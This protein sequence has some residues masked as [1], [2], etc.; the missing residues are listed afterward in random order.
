M[1]EVYYYHIPED[2]V[3]PADII[4]TEI[5][6][7]IIQ[8]YT[9]NVGSFCYAGKWRSQR[10][11]EKL[12]AMGIRTA[13]TTGERIDYLFDALPGATLTEAGLVMALLNQTI[14]VGTFAFIVY[15]GVQTEYVNEIVLPALQLKLEERETGII[16]VQ[17]SEYTLIQNK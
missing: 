6:E 9:G 1:K 3:N 4:W 13:S 12:I 11:T 5:V 17:L 10:L 14:T 7:Q 16:V 8:I 15:D 2:T